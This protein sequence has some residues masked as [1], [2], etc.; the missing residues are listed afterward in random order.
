VKTD[1]GFKEVRVRQVAAMVS[2]F[3]GAVVSVSQIHNH[4]RK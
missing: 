4:M 2:E 1:K 3:T